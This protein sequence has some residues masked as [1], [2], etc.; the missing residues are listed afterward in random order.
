MDY[1]NFA[2]E[3]EEKANSLLSLIIEQL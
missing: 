2:E 1:L 3:A